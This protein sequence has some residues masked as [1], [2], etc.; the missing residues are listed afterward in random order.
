MTSIKRQRLSML[1]TFVLS[2][3]RN[4][5]H[6]LICLNTKKSANSDKSISAPKQLALK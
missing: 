2:M 6:K 1:T 4:K 5:H 3:R